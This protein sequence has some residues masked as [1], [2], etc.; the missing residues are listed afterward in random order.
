[1][2]TQILL[3]LIL[4]IC[5]CHSQLKERADAITGYSVTAGGVRVRSETP[6]TESIKDAIE[7][8]LNAKIRDAVCRGYKSHLDLKEYE[9][10]ILQAA[11]ERFGVPVLRFFTADYIDTEYDH[12]DE[13]GAHFIYVGGRY[14]D[15]MIIVPSH[16]VDQ[17]GMLATAVGNEAEHKIRGDVDGKTHNHPLIP[18]CA[19]AS[20]AK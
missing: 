5:G 11:D 19:A 7:Q 16:R 9:V 17:L 12:V 13:S 15:G 4:V 3:L 1:M 2:K 14:E 10:A 20:K 18:P 6:V 8:G